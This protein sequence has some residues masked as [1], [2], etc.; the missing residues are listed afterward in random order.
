MIRKNKVKENLI[1]TELDMDQASMKAL[2]LFHDKI[3]INIIHAKKSGAKICLP[4]EMYIKFIFILT[5]L[6]VTLFFLIT[7][8]PL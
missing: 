2:A 6:S 3:V 7:S 4:I 5:I 1:K 8:E